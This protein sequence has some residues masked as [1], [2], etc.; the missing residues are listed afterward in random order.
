[1]GQDRAK[2]YENKGNGSGKRK[3]SNGQCFKCGSRG[4]ISY[5]CLLKDDKC[6]NC[7]KLRHKAE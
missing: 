7:G 1:K 4:H 6:F 3:Q 2:P 5:D